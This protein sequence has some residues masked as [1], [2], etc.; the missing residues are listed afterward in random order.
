VVTSVIFQDAANPA[1]RITVGLNPSAQGQLKPLTCQ[2][3]D[4]EVNFTSANAGRRFLVFV[5]GTGGTS[6]NL[7][8]LPAGAPAGCPLGN[9]QGLQP[10]FQCASSTTPT[11]TPT[12]DIA[13]VTGCRLDRGT[14]GVFFLEVTGTNIKAGALV[15]VGG[16]SPKKIKVVEVAPGTTNPTKLKLVKRVCGGLPGA[17]IITNPGAPASQP[18]NCTE[19]CPAQ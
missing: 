11:P 6:R 16:V 1:N 4:V 18:F 2:L 9:E 13:V 14:N 3:L 5:V 19:R 12:P 17:V 7:T 10:F 8:T 15:S